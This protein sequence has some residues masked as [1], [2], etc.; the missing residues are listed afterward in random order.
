MERKELLLFGEIQARLQDY[1]GKVLATLVKNFPEVG[2]SECERVVGID[3]LDELLQLTYTSFP[4]N[5]SFFI[6]L[7]YVEAEDVDGFCR[8]YAEKIRKYGKMM[9]EDEFIEKVYHN[10]WMKFYE[11]FDIRMTDSE[12]NLDRAR[13]KLHG[14]IETMT[15]V[16]LLA[17]KKEKTGDNAEIF[18]EK[19]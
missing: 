8:V 19:E 1:C 17:K 2:I 16:L 11:L 9:R 12:E 4:Y 15:Y 3:I 13:D 14:L 18:T 6:P 10:H 7:H 5:R